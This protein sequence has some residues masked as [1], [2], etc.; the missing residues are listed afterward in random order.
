MVNEIVELV[1]ERERSLGDAESGVELFSDPLAR[2]LAAHSER[3]R[4]HKVDSEERG[5]EEDAK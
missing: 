3:E 5:E 2:Y 1:R 4:E